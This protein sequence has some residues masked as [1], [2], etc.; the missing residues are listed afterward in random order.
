M[1][2]VN[3]ADLIKKKVYLEKQLDYH[4]DNNIKLSEIFSELQ[5]LEHK[6]KTFS[7][8]QEFKIV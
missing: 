6:L 5:K 1:H 2:T 3:H 7:D 8:Y 4:S